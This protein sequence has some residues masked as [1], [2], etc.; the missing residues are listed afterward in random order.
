MSPAS[1]PIA[2]GLKAPPRLGR[3]FVRQIT[4]GLFPAEQREAPD[5]GIV[6]L[7]DETER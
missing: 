6:L 4:Q 2:N 1:F 5:E 7:T 3:V